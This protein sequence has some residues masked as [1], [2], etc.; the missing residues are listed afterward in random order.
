MPPTPKVSK[1][2]KD[3]HDKNTSKDTC[4]RCGACL[5]FC[6]V[7]Q[8]HPIERFSPR[9]KYFLLRSASIKK[10]QRLIKET[11]AA[12][13]QCGACSRLCPSG[14]DVADIIRAERD[15]VAYFRSFPYSLFDIWEKLG[16]E[17]G[18]KAVS[19][20]E[21]ISALLRD[22]QNAVPL[23]K[24]PF[25][26]NLNLYI[27]SFPGTISRCKVDER[28]KR[29]KVL[30]FCGCM[31]NHVFPDT[32]AK[33][34]AILDW[35]LEIPENQVCCGLPA[36]SQGAM[37][38]ARSFAKKNL[39][40][41]LNRQADIILTGCASCAYMIKSW[42]SL[43]GIQTPT[44]KHATKIA[45]R[46]MEFSQFMARYQAN[47]GA[48]KN[49]SIAIQIPCHQRYGL[50]SERSLITV[51]QRF[52]LPD[53]P[54]TTLGCC[55]LGGT[56]SLFNPDISKNIFEQ[57]IASKTGCFTLEKTGPV[58]TTCSGCLLRLRH[59]FETLAKE[60]DSAPRAYHLVDLMVHNKENPKG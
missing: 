14:T 26:S 9:G 57:N 40:I 28:A 10:R 35:E 52:L 38:R 54:L 4:A 48:R 45:T 2:K 5:S 6:P 27:H 44:Y 29:A 19:F 33:I 58:F 32:A 50:D 16:Q 55:G 59:A 43:F 7:Y 41:F 18:I 11:I 31:Q 30:L 3:T 46:V 12:C 42:P 56:F 8:S 23:A 1:T 49:G 60:E 22:F 36:Y 17:R 20:L 39:D 15:R 21:K 34:A 37:S 24:A 47:T 53:Q 51:A 13:L 25:L